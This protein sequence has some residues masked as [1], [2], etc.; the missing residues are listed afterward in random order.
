MSKNGKN[1]AVDGIDKTS[2]PRK[3]AGHAVERTA[4]AVLDEGV[5]RALVALDLTRNRHGIKFDSRDVE[6]FE[7][8]F[9]VCKTGAGLSKKQTKALIEAQRQIR[10]EEGNV[11]PVAAPENNSTTKNDEAEDSTAPKR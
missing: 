1:G 7:K 10:R 9:T 6:A 8:L 5:P 4:K 2:G 3:R 11:Y